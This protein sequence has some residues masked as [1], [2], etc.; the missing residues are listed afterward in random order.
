[1]LDQ[2]DLDK[3][4]AMD[5]VSDVLEGYMNEAQFVTREGEGRYTAALYVYDP[6]QKPDVLAGSIPDRQLAEGTVIM[7]EDY[8]EP[9]GFDSAQEA[10]GETITAQVRQTIG[11]T[12]TFE[13]EIAAVSTRSALQQAFEPSTLYL[14]R[15]DSG[16]IHNFI[17][18]NTTQ[19]GKF[20]YATLVA[21]DIDPE[22]LKAQ[23]EG[24]GYKAVTAADAQQLLNQIIDVL[25]GIVVMFGLITLI[26]SFFGVVNT[27]YISVL[28][29]T[30]E[31]G[32]MKALGMS[33]RA[34]SRLFIVEATWIGF[35]GA[36]LGALLAILLGVVLNPAISDTLNFGDQHLLVFTPVQIIGLIAFL[37]LV[38]TVAGLLPARKATKLDPIEA[39]RTE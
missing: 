4:R 34:V 23:L 27:Q 8:L 20:L 1:M 13:F 32:L 37:M 18:E 30:R 22:E 31:I 12:Q 2:D 16:V 21:E 24:D 28:E 15:E 3:F 19:Q 17:N 36:S 10:I 7:P 33:R 35:L 9:L 5:N 14:S 6:G 26:A 11:G 38:T 29:R 25:Q 39:L